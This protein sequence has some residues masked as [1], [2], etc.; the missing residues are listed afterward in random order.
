[1]CD[2]L[3]VLPSGFYTWRSRSVSPREIADR[4]LL[5]DIRRVDAEHRGDHR[6][7]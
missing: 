4:E 2:A 3:S 1:M 5:S 7:H 6:G